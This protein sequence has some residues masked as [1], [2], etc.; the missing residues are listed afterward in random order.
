MVFGPRAVLAT[1]LVAVL[2]AAAPAGAAKWTRQVRITPR[3]GYATDMSLAL[4]AHGNAVAVGT[5]DDPPS[6][7][8]HEI[9]VTYSA[10]GRGPFG[11]PEKLLD[12]YH[13][14]VAAFDAEG[15]A[16]VA[17]YDEGS[18]FDFERPAGG[19]F[20]P[21][22]RIGAGGPPAQL[23]LSPA[24][25]LFAYYYALPSPGAAR[26]VLKVAVRPRGATRF[27]PAQRV[28]ALAAR[29]SVARL[30]LDRAG[31]AMLAWETVHRRED[32]NRV[33]RLVYSLRPRGGR[34]GPRQRLG[35]MAT[36]RSSFAL[37]SN[38]AG[39]TVAVWQA[40][41]DGRRELRAALGSIGS[42]FAPSTRLVRGRADAPAAAVAPSGDA[43]VVWPKGNGDNWP[44]SYAKTA[45]ASMS[46]ATAPPG[47]DLGSPRVVF[48]G[49][50][51]QLVAT[52]GAPDSLIA[53]W[54]ERPRGALVAARRVG[55]R[56]RVSRLGRGDAIEIAAGATSRGRV[57]LVWHARAYDAD[58]HIRASVAERGSD[59][60][61][62]A[63]IGHLGHRG[64]IY[65][66]PDLAFDRE[67]GAFAWW[68]VGGYGVDPDCCHLVQ[69]HSG[70][71]L[72]P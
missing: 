20:A 52:A 53:A 48:H 18:V 6:G 68:S 5:L 31:N 37:G 3:Y 14:P 54:R 45:H 55:G 38:R 42:G 72:L 12:S 61:P 21:P 63:T 70:S 15:T 11:P 30:A 16:H 41:R 32:G 58:K 1:A 60:G 34:F 62:V 19:D 43:L 8:I 27:E 28:S 69:E 56:W 29:A 66:G 4:D 59:L 67:D 22:R 40:V 35:L 46:V 71:Y 39:R 23:A 65:G 44:Y 26:P 9:T 25:D 47:E 10:R 17:L 13:S 49:P 64:S 57:V 51:N 50:S 7:S 2:A 24:G 33:V 36:T